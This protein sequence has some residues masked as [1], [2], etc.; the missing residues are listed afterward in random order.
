MMSPSNVRR[1]LTPAQLNCSL[2]NRAALVGIGSKPNGLLG[3]SPQI[4]FV[5][6]GRESGSEDL[7]R[8]TR[9]ARKPVDFGRG[10]L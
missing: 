4:A 1:A 3:R 9:C 6:R 2:S 8:R 10:L 5:L 7:I